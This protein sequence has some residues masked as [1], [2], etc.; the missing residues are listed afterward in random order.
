MPHR[1]KLIEDILSGIHAFGHRCKTK[2][3]ISSQKPQITHSQWYVLSII[4]HSKSISVK[5]IAQTLGISP[6]AITQLVDG[7]ADSGIVTRTED[8]TDRRTTQLTLSTKGLRQIQAI[9]KE[10][11][12]SFSSLFE[13]LS[14]SELTT[15]HRLQQKLLK[16]I[17][18]R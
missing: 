3:E 9:K 17:N 11:L 1:K 12:E 5:E 4:E 13:T 2:P 14:D 7:L 18:S 15:Y 10:K 16:Q 8:P 6:S